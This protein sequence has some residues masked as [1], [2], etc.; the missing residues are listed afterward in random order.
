MDEFADDREEKKRNVGKERRI[1]ALDNIVD[2]PE[3]H[4]YDRPEAV[5]RSVVLTYAHNKRERCDDRKKVENFRENND[6]DCNNCDCIDADEP[7]RNR[8]LVLL[9]EEVNECLRRT[10]ITA[11]RTVVVSVN[12]VACRDEEI[13]KENKCENE[14]HALRLDSRC[15]DHGKKSEKAQCH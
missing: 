9:E 2:Y 8:L 1:G 7:H 6:I 14:A 11:R 5:F 4:I 13:A 3:N 12:E 15:E 10:Y